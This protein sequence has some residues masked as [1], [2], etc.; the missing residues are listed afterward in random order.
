MTASEAAPFRCEDHGLLHH[1]KGAASPSVARAGT[2]SDTTPAP[3]LLDPR[4]PPPYGDHAWEHEIVAPARQ[5]LRRSMRSAG[6]GRL[7]NDR[8]PSDEE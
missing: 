6:A 4:A 8:L 2:S 3:P 1:M 5:R 7:Y